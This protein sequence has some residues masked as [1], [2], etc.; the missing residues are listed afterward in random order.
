LA[1][2]DGAAFSVAASVGTPR[3]DLLWLP[4]VYQGE[5]V[6]E[7]RLAPRAPGEPFSLADR[8]LLQDLARE[9]GVAVHAVQLTADLRRLNRDL[10]A[11]RVQLITAR[12]EE[13]RRLRR[14]LHDG[15]GSALTG[16]T[17]KLGASQNLLAHDPVA[18]EKLLGELKGQAQAAIADIRQLVYGLR[19]PALDELGLVSALREY[20]GHYQLDGV[21]VS[22]EAPEALPSL[23]A[24]TELAAY[25]I[26]LEA[27][28]N[29]ARHAHATT[30]AIRLRIVGEALA[31]DVEDNGVGLPADAHAGV[32]L[33]AM[34][35]RAVELGGSCAIVRRI[36]G[37]SCV[38]ARLPLG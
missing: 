24:A 19:P 5:T 38:S 30:C 16:M 9:A 35:E 2:A 36:E 25:R 12:E 37:G 32:G 17:F 7:L 27:L 10:Q 1:L 26:A 20:A 31:L 13:R 28:A 8:K 29:V 23:P 22:V 18:V 14:D 33:T 11:S 21:E 15:L 4:L 3:D 6:G 34:R